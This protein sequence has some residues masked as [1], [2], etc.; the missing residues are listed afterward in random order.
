MASAWLIIPAVL[1]IGAASY[2]HILITRDERENPITHHARFPTYLLLTIVIM[3]IW[4]LYLFLGKLFSGDFL[5]GPWHIPLLITLVPPLLTRAWHLY[6]VR[7]G[8]YHDYG[9]SLMVG[10][11]YAAGVLAALVAWIVYLVSL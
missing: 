10:F 1:T 4:F 11:L 6:T 3:M 9:T 5:S 2:A 7:P 8:G